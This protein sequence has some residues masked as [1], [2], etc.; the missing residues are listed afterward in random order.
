MDI[1]KIKLKLSVNLINLKNSTNLLKS[2]IMMMQDFKDD[3]GNYIGL[4]PGKF[5][6][7]GDISRQAYSIKYE[8]CTLS[9]DLVVDQ[10]THNQY[11]SNLDL[12]KL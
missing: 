2:V 12:Q 4:V 10:T 7:K 8:R 5:E 9:L 11:I 1:K 6:E 3:V